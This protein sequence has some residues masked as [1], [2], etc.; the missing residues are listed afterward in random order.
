MMSVPSST[1]VRDIAPSSIATVRDVVPRKI[2]EPREL[3]DERRVRGADG[4][5]ALLAHD[6]LR[7]AFHV[8]LVL[9]VDLFAEEEDDRVRI[10]FQSARIMD[11]DA[12]R[13]PGGGTGH[14]EIEHFFHPR[15]RDGHET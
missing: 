5:V 7:D 3:V 4:P 2:F 1:Y 8:F 10:L 14:G 15:G 11:D 6:D 12:V 13:K 9:L